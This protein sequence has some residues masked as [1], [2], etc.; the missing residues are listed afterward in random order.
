MHHS[1]DHILPNPYEGLNAE[2][3][4]V[5]LSRLSA[6]ISYEDKTYLKRIFP[7]RGLF[8]RITQIF[9]HSIVEELKQNGI[10]TYTPENADTARRIIARRCTVAATARDTDA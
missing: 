4:A 10:T 3:R 7:A 5:L 1:V 9:I 8:N 6:D 2:Q